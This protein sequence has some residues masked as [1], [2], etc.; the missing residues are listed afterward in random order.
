MSLWRTL[1]WDWS[2]IGPGSGLLSQRSH[3]HAHT[4]RGLWIL[5]TPME[6]PHTCLVLQGYWLRSILSKVPD[7]HLDPQKSL[8][9]A[10]ILIGRRFMPEPTEASGSG[11][12][13]GCS[14][15]PAPMKFAV[16]GLLW[17]RSQNQ[18][19]F[20]KCPWCGSIPAPAEVIVSG[21]LSP[22]SPAQSYSHGACCLRP[23]LA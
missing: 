11:P 8:V 1:A 15:L 3:T 23:A 14:R 10:Y 18:S 22:R 2:C 17:S 21:L 7:S 16:S 20:H 12:H 5:P 4:C 6:V 13:S 19:C 9:P